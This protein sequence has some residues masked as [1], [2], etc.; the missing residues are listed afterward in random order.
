MYIRKKPVE[1]PTPQTPV[2]KGVLDAIVQTWI[3]ATALLL[4]CIVTPARAKLDVRSYD[5]APQAGWITTNTPPVT[6]A[7]QADIWDTGGR[8]IGRRLLDVRGFEW[9]PQPAW[10]TVNLPVA[11]PT[12]AQIRPALDAALASFRTSARPGLD[13]RPDVWS[14][15][16]GV[17]Q[18]DP[19]VWI[20]AVASTGGRTISRSL[21]DVRA[22]EWSPQPAWLLG[23]A[24]TA[25][26]QAD[27]WDT[28]GRTMSRRPLDVRTFEW[29]P[30][31]AWITVNTPAATTAQVWPAILQAMG[32]SY[33]TPAR[34]MLDVRSFEWTPENGWLFTTL[35]PVTAFYGHFLPILGVG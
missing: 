20:G 15:A 29:A 26:Q 31:P 32:L 10:I 2:N 12:D 8:T 17:P 21:L 33:R 4:A 19:T 16:F 28:G 1:R 25:V 5:W 24:V 3:P 6:I 18:D 27:I 23:S 9:S 34:P 13:V 7:Q 30:E 14:P 35:P 22:F 11:G